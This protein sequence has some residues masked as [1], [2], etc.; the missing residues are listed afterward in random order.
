MIRHLSCAGICFILGFAAAA[1]ARPQPSELAEALAA[2]IWG[3]DPPKDALQ[4]LESGS[5]RGIS[6]AGC[7]G[8]ARRGRL[9]DPDQI[10]GAPRPLRRASRHAGRHGRSRAAIAPS[11]RR[12]REDQRRR[13][14]LERGGSFSG[15]PSAWSGAGG[16]RRRRRGASGE[17]G[18]RARRRSARRPPEGLER[19]RVVAAEPAVHDPLRRMGRRSR[20]RLGGHVS[21]GASRGLPGWL[22]APTSRAPPRSRP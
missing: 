13:G 18:P 4:A 22:C 3:D 6:A 8:P 1:E 19:K 9:H 21:G 17:A 16:I 10:G 11:R 5:D 2:A 12:G 7:G 14:A 15:R 20:S